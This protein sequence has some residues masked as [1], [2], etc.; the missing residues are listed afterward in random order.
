MTLTG[1]SAL[2]A[3]VGVVLVG[4]VGAWGLIVT[5][6]AL[7]AGVAIDVAAAGSVRQLTFTRSGASSVR[8]GEAAVIRLLVANPG[9]RRVRGRLRDA[10]PPSAGAAPHHVALDVAPGGRRWIETTLRPTRRGDRRADRVTVRSIGPLGLAGPQGSHAVP[11]SV[12]VF[13]ILASR[14]LVPE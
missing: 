2:V 7:V 13:A 11:W 10:W 4:L 8:H 5:E 1:R 6:V 9:R 12:R 3:L 14:R